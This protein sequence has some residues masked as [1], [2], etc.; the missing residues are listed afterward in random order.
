MKT[1]S[2]T[3]KEKSGVQ[4]S[5]LLISQTLTLEASHIFNSKNQGWSPPDLAKSSTDESLYWYFTALILLVC[6]IRKYGLI[7]TDVQFV[8]VAWIVEKDDYF[9]SQALL[10]NLRLALSQTSFSHHQLE[11][12]NQPWWFN[13]SFLRYSNLAGTLPTRPLL[14]RFLVKGDD[15]FVFLDWSDLELKSIFAKRLNIF[16][17]FPFSNL[18]TLFFLFLTFWLLRPFF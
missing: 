1:T 4:L 16:F 10:L 15:F 8:Y 7:K 9:L 14:I 5:L 13:S 17:S 12:I 3:R 18:K 11:P 2:I 6:S